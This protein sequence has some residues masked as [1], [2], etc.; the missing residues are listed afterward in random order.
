MPEPSLRQ[1]SGKFVVFDGPDGCGKTTQL[2]GLIRKLE[3]EGVKVRRLREPGGT[4]IGEQIRELLL[5]TKNEGMDV[6]CEMLLYMASR[7][8]LVQE[9]IRPALLA[10]ECVV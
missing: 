8:Q 6:R 9:E 7:A 5:S 2:K 10:G 3:E 4:A 1:L